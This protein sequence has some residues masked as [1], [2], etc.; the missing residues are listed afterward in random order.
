LQII[1]DLAK[2][3]ESVIKMT[4][5]KSQTAIRGIDAPLRNISKRKYVINAASCLQLII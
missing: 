4:L 3:R 5:L 2:A 1:S